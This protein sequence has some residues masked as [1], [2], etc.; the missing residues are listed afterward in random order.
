MSVSCNCIN[1]LH[2]SVILWKRPAVV[3]I[4]V[5]QWLPFAVGFG[6]FFNKNRGLRPFSVFM[7]VTVYFRCLFS[8]T[9]SAE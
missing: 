1:E 2:I 6:R 5:L 3:N 9:S 8:R 4:F 7:M